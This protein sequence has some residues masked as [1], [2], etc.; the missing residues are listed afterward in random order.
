LDGMPLG[1][2]LAANWVR[3]LTPEEIASELERTLEL[4]PDG[5]RD[6][7]QRH[8][9]LRA[10]FDHS[11][12]LL[13]ATEQRVLCQLS[14]FQGGFGR[15]A[16]KHVAGATLPSLVM[17]TD[18]SLL[19]RTQTGRYEMHPLVHWFAAGRM[20]EQPTWADEARQR[21]ATFYAEWL[22][23]R[24]PSLKAAMS[25]GDVV[26][27]IRAELENVRLAWDWMI[28]QRR[29]DL[30]LKAATCFS[31]FLETICLFREGITLFERAAARLA[32]GASSGAGSSATD[33]VAYSHMLGLQGWLSYRSGNYAQGRQLLEQSLA[34]LQPQH[35]VLALFVPVFGLGCVL[36]SGGEY[37]RAHQLLTQS[38]D[39]AR[40]G[41]N[42]WQAAY[43]LTMLGQLALSQADLRTA[44]DVLQQALAIWRIIGGGT[45]PC[46][47]RLGL[48]LMEL[49]EYAQ[50]EAL[51]Q[52]SVMISSN[53]GDIEDTA[54]A[55][56]ILA[57]VASQQGK[58]DEAIY[59]FHEGLNMFREVGVPPRLAKALV[60]LGWTYLAQANLN[61]AYNSFIDAMRTAHEVQFVPIMI[62]AL[63][64]IAT[65]TVHAQSLEKALSMT[66]HVVQHPSTEQGTRIQAQQLQAD[67]EQQLSPTQV[68][69][70]QTAV[71]ARSFGAAI[72]DVLRSANV[73][74]VLDQP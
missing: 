4:P 33:R 68:A 72:E 12:H 51:L 8:R 44:H 42:Q 13:T 28:A 39:I 70:V 38:L 60:D 17:L 25:D 59:L 32:T 18:K 9:S 35:D 63:F 15:E 48:V 43:S 22:Q 36:L 53:R 73:K 65:L 41:G 2:E 67:I 37:A 47:N 26:A 56:V 27:E 66:L 54:A 6:L 62:D 57:K 3:T 1:I 46:L 20:N 16:A 14:V 55:M 11:W 31:Y 7:P 24:E 23:Q 52:E 29:A 61:E 19:R 50:A 34:V 40:Y 10:V 64:G 30:F 74:L 69:S 71:A 49:H 58:F 45:S 21:H 5:L